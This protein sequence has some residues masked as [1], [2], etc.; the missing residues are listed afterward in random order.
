MMQTL[1]VKKAVGSDSVSPYILRYCCDELYYPVCLLFQH[2][3]R[4][5]EFPSSW[6]VSRITTLYKHKGSATDPQFYWPIAVLPTLAMV[7]KLV[8]YSQLYW[9]I[10][11]YIPPSQFGFL[12]GTGAQDCGAAMAFTATQALSIV[13]SVVLCHWT[14]VEHLIVSGGMDCYRI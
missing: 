5:G 9:Q 12:K 13:R 6:E 2:V 14:F 4:A 8:I 1:D 11:P 3:C 7:F 10:S